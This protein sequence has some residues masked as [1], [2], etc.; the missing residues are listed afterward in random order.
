MNNVI[1][2]TVPFSFEYVQKQVRSGGGYFNTEYNK[3][4]AILEKFIPKIS[5]YMPSISF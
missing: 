4:M 1:K 2:R 3:T 5:D